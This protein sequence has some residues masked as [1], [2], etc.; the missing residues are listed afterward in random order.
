MGYSPW[1]YKDCGHVILHSHQQNMR[2]PISQHIPFHTSVVLIM[3]ILVSVKRHLIVVL[4]CIFLMSNDI[5][6]LMCLL[7]ICISFLRN[8]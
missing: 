3:A 7:A 1:D 6:H 8:R 2:A 4:I 5:E